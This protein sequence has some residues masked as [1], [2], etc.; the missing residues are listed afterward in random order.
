MTFSL[1]AQDPESGMFGIVSASSSIA[2]GNRCPWARAGVGAVLTQHRTDTRAGPL[3]LDFLARGYGAQET[4]NLLVAGSEYPGQRQ[5]AALDRDGR[6]AFF[7]GPQIE[8]INAG[9]VGNRCVSVGNFL[10]TGDVPKAMVDAYEAAHGQTFAERLLAALD[11]GIAE[12]GETQPVMAA[13][14][15]IVDRHSWPLVDLRVDFE[16]DPHHTLRRLWRA[17]EPLVERFVTQVL[18]P[19]ELKPLINSALTI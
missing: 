18:R 17:Y 12:G 2:V 13:S 11:A 16:P 3:G 9:H 10:A 6:T 8:S 1:A 15:L 4:V 7:N 19:F 5:F 14:L